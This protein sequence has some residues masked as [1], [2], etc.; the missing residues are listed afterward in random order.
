MKKTIVLLFII[1]ALFVWQA[2]EIFAV[3]FLKFEREFGGK[4]STDGF[5]SKNI[6]IGFDATGNI[7]VSDADNRLVQKLSPTGEFIMQIPKER[8]VDSILRKPG[9][10]AV[11]NSDNIYVVDQAIP[12]HIPETADPR[13]YWFGPCVYKFNRDGELMHTYVVDA[14]DV[15]P[16]V[17]LPTRLM[18][19][20]EGKTAFAYQPKNYDRAVFIDVNSQNQ[21]YVLDAKNTTVHKFGAEG[22]KL[23]TFGR[24][25][26]GNGEFDSDASDIEI[27][28]EGNVFIADTGNH[29]VVKFNAAGKFMSSFGTRGRGEGEFIKPIA[30]VTLSTGE[31]LVK[32]KSQFK[33]FLGSPLANFLDVVSPSGQGLADVHSTGTGLANSVIDTTRPRSAYLNPASQSSD[34]AILHRRI[35]LLEEAE[36]RRYLNEYLD[37]VDA[38][39][40]NKQEEAED[41]KIKEIRETIYHNVIAR[42]QRFNSTGTYKGRVVYEVDRRSAE[43]H[44]LAFLTLDPLGHIYLRDG[45]D[46]IIRQYSIE[47][48]TVKPSHMNAVYNSRA[49]NRDNDFIEDYEDIDADADVD[50]QLNLLQ[51]N[52]SLFWTYNL[53]ERWNLT[54]ADVFT[55][56][57]QDERYITPPKE[58]DSYDFETQAL[59]NTAVANLKFIINPNAYHYKEFNLYAERIDGTTDLYQQSLFPDLNR[60]AQEGEGDASSLAIGGNWDV[61]TD[62]NLWLEY[63]DLNPA[64]TSR[65]FVRRY[66]DASGNLYEV[67][68]SRNQAKQ[69]V[70]ELTV[71]F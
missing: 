33:R 61:F 47:G 65:N 64:E 60:Q 41:L 18:I 40:E 39:D 52:N 11:D 70:G 22:K 68:G 54:L 25:G 53:S 63:T 46:L 42:I 13:L 28:M 50:D 34:L 32:D 9:D 48:F 2:T 10:V 20:E 24:Y 8:T 36:Y 15:R 44:D 4:G 5:F 7:Y 45:S 37:E 19:D 71:K 30:L 49:V 12:H 6:R 26:G 56:A 43:D 29:R 14:I 58:E 59:T 23:N 69:F 38:K 31:I 16:K 51:L 67:F 62:V 55:Y 66:F 27:D 21:L 3:G 1:A 57:E 17:V 35:R